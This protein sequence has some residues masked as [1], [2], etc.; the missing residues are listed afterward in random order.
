MFEGGDPDK[1]MVLGALHNG[2]HP[3]PFNSPD[4]ATDEPPKPPDPPTDVKVAD[5]GRNP[6]PFQRF[7]ASL[8][9]GTEVGGSTDKDGKAELEEEKS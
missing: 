8:D 7:I 2:T 4:I 3:P 6:V 9:D 1:P 5:Q